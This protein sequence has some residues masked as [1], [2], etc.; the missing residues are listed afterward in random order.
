MAFRGKNDSTICVDT[1]RAIIICRP[2]LVVHVYSHLVLKFNWIEFDLISDQREALV[3]RIY[4]R[5]NI[6]GGS[7]I[8]ETEAPMQTI[9]VYNNYN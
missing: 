3:G 1:M 6:R 8:F 9:Q 7:R 2:T 5:I 4:T